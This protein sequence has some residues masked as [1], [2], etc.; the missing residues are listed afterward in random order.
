M[1]VLVDL[2]G[3]TP[4]ADRVRANSQQLRRFFDLQVL[5]LVL[6]L[7]SQAGASPEDSKPYQTGLQN[8]S[9]YWNCKLRDQKGFRRRGYV[10]AVK[11]PWPSE[12]PSPR[13]VQMDARSAACIGAPNTAVSR[14]RQPA[15]RG[16]P[17][18][19]CCAVAGGSAHR[20]RM[21][22]P[23]IRRLACRRSGGSPSR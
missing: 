1:S 19:G 15:G 5:L 22:L 20:A 14:T 13:M 11:L 3:L 12:A 4:V 18:G 23:R 2:A 10:V 21:G 16:S 8:G 7:V 17:P 6:H 9:S